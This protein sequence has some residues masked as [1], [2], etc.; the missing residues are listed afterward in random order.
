M[1]GL[2]NRAR[3]RSELGAKHSLCRAE[4]ASLR[5]RERV[6]ARHHCP[7]ARHLRLRERGIRTVA[8]GGMSTGRT[9][10]AL[11]SGCRP[12]SLSTLPNS[13]HPATTDRKA[14]AA[15]SIDAPPPSQFLSQTGPRKAT[16]VGP[17]PHARGFFFSSTVPSS[18]LLAN[19]KPFRPTLPACGGRRPT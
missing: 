5:L 12:P 16:V 1:P 14:V 13:R 18:K 10:A 4:E 6:I 11:R 17:Q 15:V 8:C 7:R 2:W 9:S 3:P 19:R